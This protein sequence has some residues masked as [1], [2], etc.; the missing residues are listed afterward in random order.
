MRGLALATLFVG[1]SLIDPGHETD[2]RVAITVARG[3]LFLFAIIEI[4][5]GA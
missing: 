1:M 4:G 3:A 2:A 5:L